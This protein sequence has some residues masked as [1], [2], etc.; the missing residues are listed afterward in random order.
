[1]LLGVFTSAQAQTRD[2]I[3]ITGAKVGTA[4]A[5]G[6]FKT[7]AV[8]SEHPGV[9]VIDVGDIAAR[10]QM[11]DEGYPV[12]ET[13]TVTLSR[14]LGATAK[15][16]ATVKLG[17]MRFWGEGETITFLPGETTKTVEIPVNIEPTDFYEDEQGELREMYTWSGNIPEIF[18]ITT[19]YADADY[20]ALILKTNRTDADAPRESPFATKLE[21]LQNTFG[22]DHANYQVT[23]WGDYILFRFFLATDV[24]IGAD[25]R[26]VI[27]ARFADHTNL[28]P[29]DDDYGMAQTHEV[30]LHPINAGS[31]CSEAW[32]I[33]R[34]SPDEYL[35]SLDVNHS[36]YILWI[37]CAEK[38]ILRFHN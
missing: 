10:P 37:F 38:G 22:N 32:Y 7:G 26:Y 36:E 35:H 1:M 15:R 33:Y 23:R 18:T 34:P 4:D 21:V 8:S 14:P 19:T 31:V 30:E 29:D 17:N 6:S 3:T 11:D 16:A 9:Y 28:G 25:S 2:V 20:D 5:G 24:K 27:N 13:V 12:Y